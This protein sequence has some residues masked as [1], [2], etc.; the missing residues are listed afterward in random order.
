MV[1]QQPWTI[2]DVSVY[3]PLISRK[4]CVWAISLRICILPYFSIWR[5]NWNLTSLIAPYLPIWWSSTRW[6]T[7]TIILISLNLWKPCL[8]T[9][10]SRGTELWLFSR[11]ALRWPAILIPTVAG[12]WPYKFRVWWQARY[13]RV[14]FGHGL[15][16][17]AAGT[18]LTTML[19]NGICINERFYNNIP[20]SVQETIIYADTSSSEHETAEVSHTAVLLKEID[21]LPRNIRIIALIFM[22]IALYS[23]I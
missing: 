11:M 15:R 16:S 21:D 10:R 20:F 1:R 12:I 5:T 22:I 8:S 14:R 7:E 19:H 23:I 6:V 2:C 17:V 18:T 13:S 3:A 9:E 4:Y